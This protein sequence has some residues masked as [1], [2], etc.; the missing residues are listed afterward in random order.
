MNSDPFCL[1]KLCA[2]TV[3]YNPDIYQLTRQIK[4]LPAEVVS[5]LVDNGSADISV[6]ALR[7]LVASRNKML[8]IC[9][10]KNEGLAAAL[11]QGISHAMTSV[12]GC[13][14]VLLLDQD[15]E[16][17][18]DAVRLLLEAHVRLERDGEKVGG[19]GPRLLDFTTNL[20]HG[21]HCMGRWRWK[22]IFPA[23]DDTEIVKNIY[24]NGSGTLARTVVFE[25]HGSYEKMLF[26][27]HVD[28]EWGF[29]IHSKGLRFYGVPEAKFKHSMGERGIRFWLFGW[30]VWPQRSPLRHYYLFRNALLLMRRSYVPNVWK[31]WAI[32]KLLLTLAIFML[33]D[34][35]RTKQLGQ[36][37]RGIRDGLR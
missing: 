14:F 1:A 2:I 22:R 8:L 17:E 32:P 13:E 21:F 16:P 37:L 18:S 35:R 19:V 26:I 29:R 4:S 27:D 3:T 7:Q 33:M 20:Q 31:L 30:R 28:T 11:N 15:S 10:E 12:S 6:T 24:I 23:I 34:S 5:I 36:M 9:N 25:R